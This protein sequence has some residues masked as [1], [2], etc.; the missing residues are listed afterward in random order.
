VATAGTVLHELLHALSDN[1]WYF[2]AYSKKPWLN[3]GVTEYLTRRVT[4]KT[5]DDAFQ[6]I[7]A[8]FTKTSSPA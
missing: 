5:D 1:G 2:W 4:K 7:E 3:E 6:G 8:A